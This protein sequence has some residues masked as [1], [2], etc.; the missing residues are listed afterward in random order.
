MRY[1][2]SKINLKIDDDMY[3]FYISNGVKILTSNTARFAGGSELV[4]TFR[5]IMSPVEAETEEDKQESE[6]AAQEIIQKMKQ[7]I[8]GTRR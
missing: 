4:K 3:R 5:E 1:V 6:Q 2:S 8:K 7:K